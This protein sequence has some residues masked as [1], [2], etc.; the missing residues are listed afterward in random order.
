MRT[1]DAKCL[2]TLTASWPAGKPEADI[3]DL[4]RQ[5]LALLAE[6]AELAGYTPPLEYQV[7]AAPYFAV[8]LLR[9]EQLLAVRCAGMDGVKNNFLSGEREII[10]GNLQLCLDHPSNLGARILLTQTLAGMKRVRPDILPEFKDKIALLQKEKPLSEP[11]QAVVQRIINE[12][13]AP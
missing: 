1:I 10:D 12:V 11:A 7:P 8:Y 9:L 13:F 5:L 6:Q 3:P 2:G 4:A